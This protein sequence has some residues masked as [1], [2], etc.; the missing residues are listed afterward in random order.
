MP[1]EMSPELL[2]AM[3][4]VAEKAAKRAA[5]SVHQ[6][7]KYELL[8]LEQRLEARLGQQIRDTLG[9]DVKEHYAQH[10]RIGEF[11]ESVNDFWG[12][13]I[14][15]SAEY[16]VA[17]VI[18]ALLLAFSMRGEVTKTASDNYPVRTPQAIVDTNRGNTPNP[19]EP[20]R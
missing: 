15:K 9:V 11:L 3:D 4:D 19:T 13:I 1:P 5:E 20:K 18:G 14:K 16:M 10:K 6:Q 7:M 2:K 17:G 12:G 8:E